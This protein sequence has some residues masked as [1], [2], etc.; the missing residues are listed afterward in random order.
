VGGRAVNW[1]VTRNR[2]PM[3]V[4]AEPVEDGT[5]TLLPGTHRRDAVAV[6]VQG[7]QHGTHPDRA[8]RVT[9]VLSSVGAEPVC[10]GVTKSG[11]PRHPLY[12]RGDV[13]SSPWIAPNRTI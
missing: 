2:K 5:I 11:Q 7:G 3:P 9:R 6:I 1:A 12:V 13:E 8:S 10:L 4:D